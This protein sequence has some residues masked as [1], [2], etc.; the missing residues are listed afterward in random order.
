MPLE[1]PTKNDGWYEFVINPAELTCSLAVDPV[2]IA[3]VLADGKYIPLVGIVDPDGI[4]AVA[5]IALAKVADWVLL[6]VK[7]VALAPPVVKT[8]LPVVSPV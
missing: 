6:N 4:N 5:V 1:F 8:R 3:T 2:E 7:A